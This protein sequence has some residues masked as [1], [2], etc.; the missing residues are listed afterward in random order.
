LV[1]K[2][3]EIFRIHQV[4]LRFAKQETN[5]EP[6][7][8][9]FFSQ[10]KPWDPEERCHRRDLKGISLFLIAQGDHLVVANNQSG[11]SQFSEEFPEQGIEIREES[12]SRINGQLVISPGMSPP[13]E[14]EFF[15][16]QLHIEFQLFQMPRGTTP[17]S[18]SSDDSDLLVLRHCPFLPVT[19]TVVG[20]S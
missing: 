9:Q 17:G 20:C 12:G 2:P 8:S 4:E 10:S 7:H 3:S 13:A 11:H 18:P 6:N 1:I 14:L 5:R 19:F 16:E 15:L